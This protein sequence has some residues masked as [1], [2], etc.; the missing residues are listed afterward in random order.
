[1]HT[2]I[3][4]NNTATWAHTSPT[5]TWTSRVDTLE[6]TATQKI[7]ATTDSGHS[8]DTALRITL[9]H[10][11]LSTAHTLRYALLHRHPQAVTQGN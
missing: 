1:M 2:H 11:S 8:V 5:M 3:T 9:T 4:H 6:N 7:A 10:T